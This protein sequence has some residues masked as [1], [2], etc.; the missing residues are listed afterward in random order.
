MPFRLGLVSKPSDLVPVS[1]PFS[2]PLA[3]IPMPS[4][5]ALSC[6]PLALVSKPSKPS[7]LALVP[8]ASDLDPASK[9]LALV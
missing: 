1:K 7:K 3:L 5:L 2:K 4:K 6:K 9:P 8:K